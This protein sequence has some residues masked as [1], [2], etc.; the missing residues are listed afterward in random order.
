MEATRTAKLLSH[1]PEYTY[2]KFLTC[3]YLPPVCLSLPDS[4]KAVDTRDLWALWDPCLQHTCLRHRSTVRSQH[5]LDVQE[6]PLTA[7]EEVHHCCSLSL[8]LINTYSSNTI[9]VS[10]SSVTEDQTLPKTC[11]DHI[12]MEAASF[13]TRAYAIHDPLDFVRE[14]VH[15]ALS[16]SLEDR[17]LK[18]LFRLGITSHHPLK[19]PDTSSLTWQETV[20]KCLESLRS[21]VGVPPE[22]TMMVPPPVATMMVPPPEA[23]MMVP[24]PE[25][26]MMVPSP[27]VTMMVPP[28]AATRML[29]S[30]AM[31]VPP[32]A[33]SPDP[34]KAERLVPLGV[35]V[36][37]EGMT[38]Y[39]VAAPRQCPPVPSPRQCPPVPAPRQCPPVAAPR[40]C[41]P[42]AAPRQCPPV[43]APRQCPPVAAPRQCPP[44]A[45]PRQ[46]PPVAAPR[47]CPP[48]AAPR[49]CPPVAAPR[50]CPPVAAPRQCP[51]EF[52]L[53]PSSRPE[54]PLVPSSRPEVP[55]VPS[56]RP[57]VP[58]V[59]SSRP[60]V[61][62]VPSSRP[63]VPLVPSSR[64]EFP[65]VPSSRPEFPLVPSSR[66]ESVPPERP[67]VPAPP[68]RPLVPAPPERPLVPAPPERP[69]VPA[70][71]E[72][73]LVP[74]P[75]EHPLVPAPP[76]CPPEGSFPMKI[77][78]GGYISSAWVA[79]PRAMATEIYDPP[80]PHKGNRPWSPKPPDPPWPP[81]AP[82]PPWPSG[83]AMDAFP[84]SMSSSD[85]QGAHPPP[86]FCYYVAG[87]AVREGEVLLENGPYPPSLIA[88]TCTCLII[89]HTCSSSQ[90]ITPALLKLTPHSSQGLILKSQSCQDIETCGSYKDR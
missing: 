24:P 82:D 80:W 66:P 60:E 52:P 55:L 43:A 84:L 81:E 10:D 44:V 67:L 33:A 53:V 20:F 63:E 85:I 88:F 73:P 38:G 32:P 2:L 49:Q 19:L 14:F 62:L 75:P 69:L 37:F 48:V 25:A 28:L 8:L 58:L 41:P 12:E 83:S 45:A 1:L 56:S 3:Y 21:R 39:P 77:L 9:S 31:M 86:R 46:C 42:V 65:L 64:P 59:P 72:R 47:Q 5:T 23:T 22:A 76:E 17:A 34:P 7:L 78:G 87:R 4:W 89:R 29:P 51:P 79:G 26:T 27:E 18:I 57:E 90:L 13:I 71:P 36:E 40:Q 30:A 15:F 16:S 6:R 11:A 50:Q 68:E 70:P 54:V 74:A 35:L 61:P